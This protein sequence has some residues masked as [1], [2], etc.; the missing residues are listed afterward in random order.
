MHNGVVPPYQKGDIKMRST[1]LLP[2]V[3]AAFLAACASTEEQKPADTG[4]QAPS[5]TSG[6]AP[7]A[8]GT[9]RPGVAGTPSRPGTSGT[10]GGM[11]R[12]GAPGQNAVY[13]DYDKDEIRPQF[14]GVVEDH[15]RYLRENPAVRA[16]I[17]GNAD[18]RGSRE[19]NV[20]L[21]QRRAEAVMK[22]L[23]LLGVPANRMEAVSYGEEKPRRTGHDETAW[24]EN[25]RDDLMIEAGR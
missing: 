23:S 10:S 3:L 24:A 18:E 17:E 15:A 14:R 12:K 22:A 8:R 2:L 6:T 11:A 19:Y 4:M 16:R 1:R 21:G 20:A 13:F 7:S 5:G 25:R 9:D